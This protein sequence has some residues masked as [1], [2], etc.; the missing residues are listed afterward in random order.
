MSTFVGQQNHDLKN[1]CPARQV[2]NTQAGLVGGGASLVNGPGRAWLE[3]R[4]GRV[5][6]SGARRSKDG[7][8]ARRLLGWP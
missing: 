5:S 3:A 8:Q 7:A 2:S 1:K 4:E 6:R